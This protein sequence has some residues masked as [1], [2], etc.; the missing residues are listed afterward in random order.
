MTVKVLSVQV[1]L[2]QVNTE[3]NQYNKCV[4][5]T[6]SNISNPKGAYQLTPAHLENIAKKVGLEDAE[7]LRSCITQAGGDRCEIIISYSPVKVGETWLNEKTGETGQYSVDHNKI[8]DYEIVLSESA[9]DYVAKVT[10]DADVAAMKEAR[11]SRRNRVLT[12]GSRS[13]KVADAAPNVAPTPEKEE[14]GD[15]FVE[16]KA[17][18]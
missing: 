7:L 5:V 14:E 4:V 3:L 10:L 8:V 18:K 1:P 17:K 6:P 11:K 9:L 2:L 12:L 13:I 16:P 15:P